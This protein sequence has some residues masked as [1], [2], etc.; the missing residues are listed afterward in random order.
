M[1]NDTGDGFAPGTFWKLL[2]PEPSTLDDSIMNIDGVHFRAPTTTEE[3][4]KSNFCDRPKKRNYKQ[5]FDRIP[6]KA[7]QWLLPVKNEKTRKFKRNQNGKYH[8][9]EQETNE[10]VLNFSN[11]IRFDSHPADWFN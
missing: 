3:E 5:I 4:H 7:E 9:K 10:T 6:F 11:G 2:E 8:C 1:A